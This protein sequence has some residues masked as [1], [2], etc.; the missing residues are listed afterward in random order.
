MGAP[1][2][3]DTIAAIATAPGAG[4]VAIVRLSGPDAF[5]V[6]RRV[7][8]SNAGGSL[9]ADGLESHRARLARLGLSGRT[10]GDGRDAPDVVDEV[11][12]LPMRKPRSYTGEDVVEIQC[13][14]GGTV[15]RLVLEQ[16]LAAGAR[17]ARAGEFTERAFLNGRLDLARAEAVAALIEART[18]E[19]AHA[20]ARQ[21]AGELSQR[22]TAWRLDLLDA[23]S[24][25]EVS[26][27][28]ADEE[29]P[30]TLESDL[31]DRLDALKLAISALAATWESGRR[32]RDG[33][34]VVLL[35]APNA[36][37]SS[38]FNALLGRPRAIVAAAPGTTRDWIEEEVA[39]AG[40][41]VLLRDTA[42]VRTAEEAVEQAGIR[43]ALELARGADLTLLLL[44]GSR[45]PDD[46]DRRLVEATR[47]LRRLVV[48]TKADLAPGW[49]PTEGALPQ[50]AVAVSAV[51][52]SGLAEL[53]AQVAGK[54]LR[55]TDTDGLVVL[56]E[57]H[58]I[59]LA[60][61]ASHLDEAG[62]ILRSG[63][64]LEIVALEIGAAMAALDEILGQCDVEDLLDR[65]FS[66]FC[67]GK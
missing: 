12:V 62:T 63:H 21:V 44:D 57:R 45:A 49:A 11:L 16:C 47:D 46:D 30:L 28:F 29:L 61:A 22:L 65:I 32:L 27:D 4:A 14:G 40:V 54:L 7:L 38:L 26:L 55:Q 24:L 5:A 41:A 20:A 36:G 66:R 51:E 37:K 48:R 6:A 43:A 18:T 25:A 56:H 35:G 31:R 19:A 23:R 64:D 60:R 52:E 42:G 34:T 59:A 58:A 17:V 15:P 53:R 2:L 9:G 10:S 67:V 39:I 50:V 8:R 13:H 1:Y 33:A 3:A